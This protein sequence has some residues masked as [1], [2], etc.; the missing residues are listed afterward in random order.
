MYLLLG[1]EGTGLTDPAAI[2]PAVQSALAERQVRYIIDH[3]GRAGPWL[4]Q[5]V[6]WP[7]VYQGEG[8]VVYAAEAI[9]R[10]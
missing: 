10:K 8:L 9:S 6:G 2:R 4:E 7:V 3:D 5:M 1:P